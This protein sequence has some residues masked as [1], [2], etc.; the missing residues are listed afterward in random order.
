MQYRRADVAP[1]ERPQS[2]NFLNPA[3]RKYFIMLSLHRELITNIFFF[4]H[5]VSDEVS[6]AFAAAGKIKGAKGV[7]L[8]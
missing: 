6:F 8:V 3:I 7:I 4:L 1:M 5:T 2:I